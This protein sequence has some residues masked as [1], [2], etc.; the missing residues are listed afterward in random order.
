MYAP[1]RQHLL[2]KLEAGKNVLTLQVM[3][4]R[5][6]VLHRIAA[7]QVFQNGLHRIPQAANDRFPVANLGI[8][9]DAR[10]QRIHAAQT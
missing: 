4:L 10:K 8:D 9:G 5:Q 6:Q 7:G 1:G 3:K 2:R